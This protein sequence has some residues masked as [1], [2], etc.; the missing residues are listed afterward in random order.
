MGT[1]TT[2]GTSTPGVEVLFSNQDREG[3]LKKN[4]LEQVKAGKVRCMYCTELATIV[5][6]NIP[7]CCPEEHPSA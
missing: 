6:E 2:V 4:F 7:L 1:T 5:I 3:E